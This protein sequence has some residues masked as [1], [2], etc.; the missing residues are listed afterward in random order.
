MRDI[1][2]LWRDIMDWDWDIIFGLLIPVLLVGLVVVGLSVLFDR[3][4][5]TDAYRHQCLEHG[6]PTLIIANGAMFCSGIR[7]G[8]SIVIP[9][10]EVGGE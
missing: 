7:D 9:I 5:N 10:E 6:Y 3:W 8:Q 2:Y 4:E 1:K